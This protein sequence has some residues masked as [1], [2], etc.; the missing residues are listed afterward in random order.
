[1]TSKYDLRGRKAILTF[2]G[3]SDWQ[4]VLRKR[5]AGAPI[6]QEPD[7]TWIA[8]SEELDAWSAGQCVAAG[9]DVG[10]GGL[11]ALPRS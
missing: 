1:M 2:W 9:H 5:K 11:P 7:G 8:S 6:K 4:A 10:L 3:L